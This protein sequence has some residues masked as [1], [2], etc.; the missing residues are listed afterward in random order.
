MFDW[1]RASNVCYAYLS[2]VPTA[3]ENP[4]DDMS[5]FRQSKWFTR[6]WTLQELLAPSDVRFFDQNWKEIGTKLGFKDLLQSITG[7]THLFDYKDASVAQKLSWV[8][9]RE[10]T[11]LEDQAYCLLGLFN[12]N[13][14][15]LYGEGSAAFYRL[16]LEILSKTDD[17]TIFAWEGSGDGGLLA[18][19][20]RLFQGAENVITTE[21]DPDR[22]P[23]TMTS[24][25]LGLALALLS[26][27]SF[28][29]VSRND[30]S[31]RASRVLAPI[32]CKRLSSIAA[33]TESNPLIALVLYREA[34]NGIWRRERQ[35]MAVPVMEYDSQNLERTLVYV[36][37]TTLVN[38][39][40]NDLQPEKRF[41]QPLLRTID[42]R[43]QL[44]Q[45]LN[46]G[47]ESTDNALLDA[48]DHAAEELEEFKRLAADKFERHHR[49]PN[50]QVIHRVRCANNRQVHRYVEEP[51]VVKSGRRGHH[52]RGTESI[53][54]FD[55]YIEKDKSI[56]FI[57]YRDYH[58]CE[59]GQPQFHQ[60]K[61]SWMPHPSTLVTG[62]GVSIISPVLAAA[63]KVLADKT[64]VGM[65]HP[66]FLE[67]G[68]EFQ[69]PYLWYFHGRQKIAQVRRLLDKSHQEH[70]SIFEEYLKDRFEAAWGEVDSLLA[71]GKISAKYIDYLYVG[72]SSF[73]ASH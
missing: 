14:P 22:P 17:D 15:L 10:T 43:K 1:Y 54:D 70:I 41:R 7:I 53:L 3:E 56:S 6:G 19:S 29:K 23:Y 2:D 58:C 65:P 51:F 35:T 48:L 38:E 63:L 27:Q 39:N 11:R 50:Y 66:N 47:F 62:E 72:L 31:R 33:R 18:A 36:P 30:L 37:Q 12:V 20:P 40:I 28:E 5:S 26:P 13:M 25:G 71:E 46:I 52:L 34:G 55:L 60:T 68:N 44:C 64:L 21:F 45:F 24:K 67:V 9:Q 73:L 69:S 59:S 16:Q 4:L 42:W 61:K 49:P 57:V 32:N 8:S